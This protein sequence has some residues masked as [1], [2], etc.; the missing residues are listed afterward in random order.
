MTAEINTHVKAEE[1][2]G[3]LAAKRTSKKN[4]V[5]ITALVGRGIGNFLFNCVVQKIPRAETFV[6]E[7]LSALGLPQFRTWGLEPTFVEIHKPQTCPVPFQS[8]Q[9]NN[10]LYFYFTYKLLLA[11]IVKPKIGRKGDISTLV[12]RLRIFDRSTTCLRTVDDFF[13]AVKLSCSS[14]C[15]NERLSLVVLVDFPT[16]GHSMPYLDREHVTAYIALEPNGGVHWSVEEK[17]AE[18]GFAEKHGSFLL[19]C[20]AGDADKICAKL[21]ATGLR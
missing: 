14:G 5:W 4:S 18:A 21:V 19:E 7:V 8:L 3:L 11:G 12:R 20:G 2:S 6:E 13:V 1:A 16:H 15:T 17:A 9:A 10:N